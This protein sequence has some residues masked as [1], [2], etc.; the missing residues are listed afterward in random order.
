MA[1]ALSMK[2]VSN[3]QLF[4]LLSLPRVVPGTTGPAIIPS[5]VFLGGLDPDSARVKEREILFAC[6]FYLLITYLH[7]H[8][9]LTSTNQWLLTNQSRTSTHCLEN[10]QT[11]CMH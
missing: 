5:Q 7:I 1:C 11:L 3:Y 4:F 8:C 9:L 2:L 6:T 10:C